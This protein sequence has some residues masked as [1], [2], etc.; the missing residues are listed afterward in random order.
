M[1]S[2]EGIDH[3]LLYGLNQARQPWLTAV[4][5]FMGLVSGTLPVAF[6][7]GLMAL[8]CARWSK[9]RSKAI[10]FP[11]VAI[12]GALLVEVIK[13]AVERDRPNIV[14]WGIPED[15]VNGFS[16]PSGHASINTLFAVLFLATFL[17]MASRNSL[18]IGLVSLAIAWVLAVGFNR[19]YLGVHWPTDVLAGWC[20]GGIL[21]F[22]G[23]KFTD[24]WEPRRPRP[25]D[26]PLPS[27]R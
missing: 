9:Q 22:A 4:M 24:Y 5:G 23:L 17:P 25:G 13:Q 20:L 8:F 10:I 11:M 1:F 16:F 15:S 2:L 27:D 21:G 26:S 12:I 6:A 7:I 19:I 18:R 14:P 3:G